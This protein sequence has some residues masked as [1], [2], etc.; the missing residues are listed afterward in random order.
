MRQRARAGAVL[1]LLA[2]GAIAATSRADHLRPTT[3]ELI[4]PSPAETLSTITPT[5]IVRVRDV[6]AGD[7]PFTLGLQVGTTSG[8]TAPPLVDTTVAGDSASITLPRALPTGTRVY[9]RATA[10]T[11][12]G[13]IIGS[14][15][16]TR[17]VPRWLV[18]IA[19]NDPNGN[20]LDAQRP[21]FTWRSA[22]VAEPPGPWRYE[23][24]ILNVGTGRI[25]FFGNLTD[26][27]V[28]PVTPIQFNTSYR[29][30]V[31]ARLED[32]AET[33]VTS[34]SSFVVLD[35]SVPLASLLYQNF[36]NPFPTA[37]S[38]A[39]CVWFDLAVDSFVN[40]EVAD[41]RGRR[42][43]TL[44]PSVELPAFFIAGRHGRASGGGA[45]GCN[46]TI[47]WDGRGTDGR[48]V[49]S[50]VYLLRLRARGVDVTRRIVF[51]GLP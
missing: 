14:Q 22:A 12:L 39:T 25:T 50:G 46:G 17:V 30:S 7:A 5:I 48:I 16:E 26:T 1:S 51:R 13:E 40:L 9:F 27:T 31:T 28:V 45:T 8:F 4:L 23:M 33:R 11:A 49:P 20:T 43:R 18:L 32:G 41:L 24:E 42:V 35:P 37:N 29:W 15:I 2:T 47:Q 6:S 36:P 34:L 3:V 19:P 21:R 44:I 38:A 10:R